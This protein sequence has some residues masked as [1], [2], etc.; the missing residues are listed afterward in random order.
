M[1]KCYIFTP[2]AFA[3]LLDTINLRQNFAFVSE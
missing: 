2:A 1:P 3:S